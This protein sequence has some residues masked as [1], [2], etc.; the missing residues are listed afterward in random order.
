MYGELP[1]G[2]DFG[3]LGELRALWGVSGFNAVEFGAVCGE[4]GQAFGVAG[5]AFVG[6]VVSG[7][8][9]AVDDLDRPAQAWRQ[10]QRGNGKIFV[11]VD[12]HGGRGK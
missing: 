7:T 2:D 5:L 6:N 4:S 1:G 10:Q 8:G 3:K 12:G 11:M 9:K